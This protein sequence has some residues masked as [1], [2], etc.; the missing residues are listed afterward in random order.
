MKQPEALRL[1]DALEIAEISYTSMVNA[2]Y[3]LRRLHEA[4]QAMLDALKDAVKSMG[5]LTEGDICEASHHKKEDRHG[6]F[7]P[8]PMATR[9]VFSFNKARAAIAKGEQQ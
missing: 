3:E 9:F 2:A 7:S 5:G 8:C 1:A 6:A 4:N